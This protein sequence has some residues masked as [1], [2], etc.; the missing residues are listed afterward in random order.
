MKKGNFGVGLPDAIAPVS[1]SGSGMA[2]P[3]TLLVGCTRC[4]CKVGWL[5]SSMLRH[6]KF[7]SG[8]IIGIS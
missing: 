2:V 3:A 4:F 5:G 7:M 1:F 6:P 8:S